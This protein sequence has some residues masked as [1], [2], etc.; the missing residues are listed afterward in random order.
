MAKNPTVTIDL[1][2]LLGLT[3]DQLTGSDRR[4]FQDWL[5]GKGE[6]LV[7]VRLLDVIKAKE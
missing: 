3:L 7:T 2:K 1:V 4:M 5:A 6:V